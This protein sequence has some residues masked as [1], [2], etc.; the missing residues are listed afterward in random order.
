VASAVPVGDFGNTA[1]SF[2]S[3]AGMAVTGRLTEGRQKG[4]Y[5]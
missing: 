4:A 3:K 2:F 1:V 5:F